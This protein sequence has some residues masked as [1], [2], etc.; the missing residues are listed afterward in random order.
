MSSG[1]PEA[2]RSFVPGIAGVS[3]YHDGQAQSYGGVMSALGPF[4]FQGP[5]ANEWHGWFAAM[6][7]AHSATAD[8]SARVAAAL[9]GLAR[10]IEDEHQAQRLAT[11][12]DHDV[13]TAR[14][15]LQRAQTALETMKRDLAS[16]TA[17]GHPPMPMPPEYPAA[18]TRATHELALALR[19]Q[20]KAHKHLTD[21]KDRL[22]RLCRAFARLVWAEAQVLHIAVPIP[23]NPISLLRLGYAETGGF[24]NAGYKPLKATFLADPSKWQALVNTMCW[25]GG[26]YGGGGFI[27]GPDGKPW[28]L[29]V[30]MVPD[31]HGG[32]YNASAD[33][34]GTV[35]SLGHTDKGWFTLGTYEGAGPL[36]NGPSRAV[37]AFAGG[38]TGLL[39]GEVPD[40]SLIYPDEY[41]HL[42]LSGSLPR[43]DAG[44]DA[45]NYGNHNPDDW[46][47]QVPNVDGHVEWQPSG[48]LADNAASGAGVVSSIVEGANNATKIDNLGYGGYKVTFQRNLDGR[49]RAS[50][51]FYQV[52]NNPDG[53]KTIVPQP[54]VAGP[55]GHPAHYNEAPVLRY[56]P[57]PAPKVATLEA[58][59][60][61]SHILDHLK[62]PPG[63]EQALGMTD[64]S[65]VYYHDGP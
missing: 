4:N 49:T 31:G 33:G 24:F 58:N 2:L 6:Q 14:G 19:A 51:T 57:A 5:H 60:S 26:S 35:E 45:P 8:A 13:T 18:V 65:Q 39:G 50:F 25:R 38:A 21:E 23:P 17:P 40:T 62:D 22:Q 47:D 27:I 36:V 3:S 9:P 61:G 48:E 32:F 37:L 63:Y 59:T 55:G 1:Q 52:N 34:S 46:P 41:R 7:R 56:Q 15:T 16:C 28:P 29:V 11:K 53:T 10:A 42:D 20:T 64:P 54:I 12:A 43:W 44:A 30:P